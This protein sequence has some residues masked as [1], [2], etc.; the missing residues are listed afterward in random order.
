MNPGVKKKGASELALE[1]S[2]VGALPGMLPNTELLGAIL[3]EIASGR[4]HSVGR[5]VSAR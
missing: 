3:P 4:L 5:I 2:T 1:P